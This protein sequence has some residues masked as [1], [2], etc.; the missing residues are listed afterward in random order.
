VGA[1]KGF[2]RFAWLQ[3]VALPGGASAIKEPWRMGLSYLLAVYGQD[4]SNI[5]LP[6]LDRIKKNDLNIVRQM[7]RKK[8]NSPQTSGC[9]RLFD[10]VSAILGLCDRASFEAEAAVRLEMISE[11]QEDGFY[12]IIKYFKNRHGILPLKGFIQNIVSDFLNDVPVPQIAARFHNTLA[13]LFC[14]TALA[15]RE[16]YQINRVGLSGGVYQNRY[17]FKKIQALLLQNDFELLTHA[18]VPANDGGLALGQ[19]AI[20]AYK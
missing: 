4:L 5:D 2:E 16:K 12:P 19:I 15:A 11:V 10:G 6:F 8:I 17:F 13:R 3:P 20:A 14:E 18:Q 7:I 1:F 9:G